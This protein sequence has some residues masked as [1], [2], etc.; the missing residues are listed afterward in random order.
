M[1]IFDLILLSLTCFRLTRLIVYDDITQ[2]F[3]NPFFIEQE[4]LD[5]NGQL[6]QFYLPHPSRLRGW[7]GSLLS[8]YWCTGIWV[9]IGLMISFSYY[10]NIVYPLIYICSIAAIAAIIETIIQKIQNE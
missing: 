8:C 6:A 10:P 1:S 7:I 5:E 3:R 4:E 2:I 9:S